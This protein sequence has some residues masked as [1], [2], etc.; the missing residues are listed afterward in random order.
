[1]TA[2]DLRISD[3]S[4]D[5][6]SSD[7]RREH[8]FDLLAVALRQIVGRGDHLGPAD[9]VPI[10]PRDHR[11]LDLHLLEGF[12]QAGDLGAGRLTR[13]RRPRQR[14]LPAFRQRATGQRSEEHTSELQTLMRSSYAAFCLTKK[15]NDNTKD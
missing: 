1:M 3:W 5:V 14:K 4:S 11:I 12:P 15:S 2:Y 10:H 13:R 8:G 6:C 9:F 7:L